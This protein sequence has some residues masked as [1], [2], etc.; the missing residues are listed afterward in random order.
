MFRGLNAWVRRHTV[1]AAT[2]TVAVV[3]GVPTTFAVL[4]K[5][6]PVEDV[7]LASRDVWVTN[8][9]A[10]LGGRLNHQIDELDASVT[11]SSRDLD[12]LQDGGAYFL[13]DVKNGT[14]DRIDQ[15]YSSLVD[16]VSVPRSSQLS[17]GGDT[18]AVLSGNGYLWVVD[19]SGRLD[20]DPAKTKPDAKLGDGSRVVVGK[21][22][23]TYAVSPKQRTLVTIEHPGAAP[24]KA[25][26][27]SVAHFQLSAVGDEPV[28]LD[29]DRNRIITADASSISLPRKG[30]KLQQ[31]SQ[32]NDYALIAAGTGLLEAPLRGGAVRSVPAGMTQ[33]VTSPSGTSAPVWLNGCAYGAWASAA[34]Y[35]YACDGRPASAVEIGRQVS[36][37]DLEFRVN[38]DV[39][40]LNDLRNGD[41]WV[42]SSHLRLVQNWASLKPS[43]VTKQGDKGEEKPVLQSFADTLAQRTKV[44]RPPKA[45]NDDFGVRAGRTTELPVLA[46]DTD[47]DGDVL[48]V[49][50]FT[51]IPAAQGRIDLIDGGRSLQL[52][53][54]KSLSGTVSFRYTVDDGRGGTAT[55]QV[56]AT[57]HPASENAAPKSIHLSSTQVEVGQS[58]TYNVLNDWADPDGDGLTLADAEATT[59]DNVQ[60]APD[61]TVTFTSK[62][63]QTGS[64]Q[65]RVTV[66]DGHLSATGTLTVT[67]KPAGTL[68]PV[69]TP[70]YANGFAGDQVVVHPLDNDLS[71]SG[72]PLS[73]VGASEDSGPAATVT[74]DTDQKTVTIHGTGPGEYYVK[75]TLGAGSKSTVGLVRVDL[76][77]PGSDEP[78]IAVTDTVY[79]RAGE[80]ATVDVLDNDVS[81]SGRVLAVQSVTKGS[82]A[83]SLSIEV[84]DN[85]VVKVT[86]PT[87]LSTQVQLSYVV[88]DGEHAAT[89]GITVVPVPPLV[90]HQPPLA[91]DDTVTVRAGD[92]ATV[93]VLN[94]DR[95]PDDE[96][97]T[98]D[99]TLHDTSHAGRG[100]VAFVSG[101]TVR[102]QAPR[103][104]GQ[105][106]VTY[107]IT[108]KF[109]QKA[110]ADV[111]FVVTAPP[112]GSTA[113]LAPR[114]KPLT[115]R[116]FA[117]STVPITVP[118]NGIDPDGDS[119]AFDS[120]SGSPKLGETSATTSTGFRYQAYPESAGTD[121]FQYR[122]SDTYGRSATGVVRVGVIPRPATLA[123]PAA[124]NDTIEVK[125]GKTAS[126]PVLKNDSDPNGFPIQLSRSLS[127]VDK[128]LTASVHG[129]FVLV[130]APQKEGVYQLRYQIVNGHGGQANAFVQVNVTK[131][132]KPQYP[133][134]ADQIVEP[135]RTYRTSRIDV[136]V[137]DGAANPSG[138]VD[139]LT[140]A[141]SGANKDAATVGHDGTVT[142]RPGA[143]RMAITYSL[144]DPTTGLSGK[145]FIIVPPKS[146]KPKNQ[147]RSSGSKHSNSKAPYLNPDLPKQTVMMNG[148]RTWS[149]TDILVVPSGRPVS[150]SGSP[151]ATHGTSPGSGQ[152]AIGYA[153]AKDYRGPAAIRFVVNDGR[154]AGGKTDRLTSIEL[155]V[156]VGNADQSDVPP[157]FT[158]PDLTVEPGEAART[159]DLRDSTYHPN[160]AVKSKITYTN[161]TGSTSAIHGSLA[162][163]TLTVSSPLGTQPGVQT[164]IAFNV[165]SGSY[166]IKGWA[167]VTVVSS[168]RPVPSQ[169]KPPQ[170]LDMKRGQ[171]E[172][173]SDATSDTYWV[174]PFPGKPL[175]ILSAKEVTGPSGATVTN[176]GTSITVSAGSGAGIGTVNIQYIV[177]DATNDP[178]RRVTGQ[179]QLTIHDVPG[180]PPV[181]TIVSWGSGSVTLKIAAA[182]SNGSSITQ[183]QISNGSATHSTSSIGDYT[184]TGLTNG[185]S[186]TFTVRAVN[187]DGPGAWSSP[188]QSV[189]PYGTPGEVGQP[190]MRSSGQYYPATVTLTWPT[191]SSSQTGGGDV[192]YQYQI[193]KGSNVIK[194]G[195]ITGL[196]ASASA[197]TS[198]TYSGQVRAYNPNSDKYGAWSGVSNKVSITKKPLTYDVNLSK[199]A[200]PVRDAGCSV[201]CYYYHISV[202]SFPQGTYTIH[203]YCPAGGG[204]E[205]YTDRMSVGSNGS[206]TFSSSSSGTSQFRCG[207]KTYV[208]VG[209]HKS[210][211]VDFHP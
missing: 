60:F 199:G 44:N 173:L 93:P 63:G 203:Y 197:S 100:A 75:Y 171:T 181:P 107:G 80:S 174:N 11:G 90:T 170:K 27:P 158:P 142:V 52:T 65:V 101:S 147:D 67:V 5:G 24:S 49:T 73:L 86:A 6:F 2:V 126:V 209:G 159:I 98:L 105:Y 192:R 47:P 97:F 18:L 84:L 37:D 154:D 189:T 28:V 23:V 115:V 183:Y 12:V 148:H 190:T 111:V 68:S 169:K 55:A 134:A 119:V 166:T 21:S 137:F 123:L 8:G 156:T 191:L 135:D 151:V 72:D 59:D 187:G 125:P 43:E 185:R 46:N 116:V 141:V 129:Q 188:S 35:L 164:K 193:L 64:K 38:H 4:H 91:S 30:L 136:D 208:T 29:T 79:V 102:Y 186:Y 48:A 139:D 81:P 175:R 25:R 179:F 77:E 184:F 109:G 200:G 210:N 146:Q 13:T 178:K 89:A 196:S 104:A 103:T 124:V 113:D 117:G 66:S 14:V 168:S 157:T 69:A 198:G 201:G 99:P 160:A 1:V 195:T 26:F 138:L 128:G 163:S 36:G 58:I 172:T 61:G 206:G 144:T 41:A 165:N 39:I 33:P 121:T 76:A 176:T 94:N 92:V 161:L 31:P 78:P 95:S 56:N 145:A 120:V 53:P 177:Q 194:S 211:T 34:R 85:A 167:N 40:A 71:P 96:P 106:S 153:P 10:L 204:A 162:G 7:N 19:A 122:V 149:L 110:E 70:D 152:A 127:D 87:V 16:R 22:G 114:P 143:H 62:N 202:S 50:S 57:V 15:A 155:P 32:T 54:A 207:Y 150:L 131:D 132:A 182:A 112:T 108:D 20:F 130:H 133:T 140:V 82:D 17:Y 42:V 3:V 83:A 45:V 205:S 118:L 74:T 180:K 9:D 51:H 88:S